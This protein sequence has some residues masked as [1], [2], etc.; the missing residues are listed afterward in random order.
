MSVLVSTLHI[1]LLFLS[2]LVFF[3]CHTMPEQLS[4]SSQS[5][6][7]VL[8]PTLLHAYTLSSLFFYLDR[9]VSRL[10]LRLSVLLFFLFSFFPFSPTSPFHVLFCTPFYVPAWGFFSPASFFSVVF[11]F[12]LHTSFTLEQIAVCAPGRHTLSDL[13]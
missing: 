10:R 6:V 5:E 7:S 11:F 2:F 1:D 8:A 9:T 4:D 3:L 12:T 13:A